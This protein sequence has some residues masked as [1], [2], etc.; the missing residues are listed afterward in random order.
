GSVT[1]TELNGLLKQIPVCGNSA[2][3]DVSSWLDCDADDAVFSMMSDDDNIESDEDEVIETS[4]I[5]N[6]TYATETTSGWSG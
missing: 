5:S 6:R 3:D 4:K 1:V 2:E